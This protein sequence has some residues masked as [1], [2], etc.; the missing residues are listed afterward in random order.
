MF[1]TLSAINDLGDALAKLHGFNDWKELGLQLGL[2]YHTL[3]RIDLEQRGRIN[4]CKISMLS[5]WL[6]HQDDVSKKGVPSWNMLKV[7]LKKIGHNDK[8]S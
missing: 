7:A 6:Q 4:D 3:E 2:F 5:A 8:C 1:F